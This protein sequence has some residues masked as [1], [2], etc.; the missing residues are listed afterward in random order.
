MSYYLIYTQQLIVNQAGHSV[1][2]V[3]MSNE[4]DVD[5]LKMVEHKKQSTVYALY[6]QK[7]A[8]FILQQVRDTNDLKKYLFCLKY[9]QTRA[10]LTDISHFSQVCVKTRTT[11]NGQ[12]SYRFI[13]NSFSI[14]KRM[15]QI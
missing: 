2:L 10:L 15:H 11:N 1:F 3:A 14:K 9:S 6:G 13:A 7:T 4:S 5:L 12:F 8:K